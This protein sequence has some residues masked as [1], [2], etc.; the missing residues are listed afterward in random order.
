MKN[1][2]KN[3]PGFERYAVNS[4]GVVINIQSGNALSQRKASNGYMRVN[5]RTGETKYE[6]PTTVAVH[7]LVAEAFLEPD[8]AKPYVNHK[9]GDKTNN[10]V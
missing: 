4:E 5:L 9:D 2:F 7:R 8:S 10:N 1:D 6:K 3:I